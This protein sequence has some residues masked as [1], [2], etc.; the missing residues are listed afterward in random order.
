M[1][2]WMPTALWIQD[3]YSSPAE[4]PM[5]GIELGSAPISGPICSA[6]DATGTGE[7]K[8]VT[9]PNEAPVRSSDIR[10]A[11]RMSRGPS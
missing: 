2:V 3:R 9:L 11:S 4:S 1:T 8:Q 10:S 7:S 6:I 5:S